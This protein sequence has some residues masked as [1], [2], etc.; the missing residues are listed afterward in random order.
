MSE[1]GGPYTL[2]VPEL[3]Y[4]HTFILYKYTW[5]HFKGFKIIFIFKLYILFPY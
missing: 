3:F 2:L 4:M 1:L 5:I